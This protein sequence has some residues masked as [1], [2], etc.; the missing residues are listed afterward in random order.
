MLVWAIVL[1]ATFYSQDVNDGVD[2]G[3][4]LAPAKGESYIFIFVRAI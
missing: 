3:P 4:L 1:T 2:R